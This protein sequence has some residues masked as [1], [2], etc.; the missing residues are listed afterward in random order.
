MLV[1]KMDRV[2]GDKETA[3]SFLSAVTQAKEIYHRK[4][5]ILIRNFMSGTLPVTPKHE[6]SLVT[7]HAMLRQ[8]S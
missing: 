5:I 8:L 1:C 6:T 2:I 3:E 7:S 4:A